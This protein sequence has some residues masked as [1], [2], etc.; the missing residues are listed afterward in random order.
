MNRKEIK[1]EAKARI[2]GNK[3]NIILPVFFIGLVEGVLET[4][5]GLNKYITPDFSNPEAMANMEMPTG[6]AIALLV[7]SLLFAII[8]VAYKKYIL[9]F[10]RTGKFEFSDIIDCFKEKWVNILV[11]S[12]LMGLVIFACTLLFVIP[13]IIMAL[14]YAMVAYVV[15]DSDLNGVDALKKSREMMKG[16]KWNY[17][18]FGLSFI[19]WILLVPFT[20]GL[21]LIWLFPYMT[22]ADALYYEGL[23]KIT[24]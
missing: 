13:G 2:K 19:G 15:I 22:V 12:I 6:V 7:I 20:F 21:L 23:K 14:A 18:V 9:N 4:I 3:W 5:F 10:V 16:Y 24:K 8:M 1:E 17:F 11:A